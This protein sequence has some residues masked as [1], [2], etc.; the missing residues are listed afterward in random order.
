[1]IYP[2][3]T[4]KKIDVQKKKLIVFDIDGTLTDSVAIHQDAFREAL[5]LMKVGPYNDKF[6][7][8]RH[9]TDF[10]IA[11]TIYEGMPGKVFD[12]AASLEFEQHL[13]ESIRK[14]SIAEIK[15]AR[16]IIHHL[17]HNSEYGV[18]YAT[19]SMH[20]P[21]GY[22]LDAAGISFHQQQLV[23]SNG[24][25]E[26]ERIISQAI[27]NAK[28]FYN[29]ACFDKIISFGDGLWDLK[30]ANNL[31]LEFIG[32]GNANEQLLRDNGMKRH[33]YDFTQIMIETL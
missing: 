16:E 6:G 29:V 3:K 31:S 22:K 33:Y 18:C 17:D 12:P 14:C 19:G 25:E 1:M 8:Y 28:E 20:R 10:H 9:H 11:K 27:A 21:A 4:F 32:I 13:Y 24:I 23:A 30:A 26:R 7:T 15:G 5:G 2:A